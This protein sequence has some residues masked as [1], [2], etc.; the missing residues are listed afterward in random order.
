[1]TP[2]TA[3]VPASAQNSQAK[4]DLAS[5]P[6]STMATENPRLTAQ[7]TRPYA[8]GR[9]TGGTTSAISAAEAGRY[10]SMVKPKSSVAATIAGRPRE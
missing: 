7:N 8:R 6:P 9:S 1:M 5:A 4:P 3:Q 10:R 2:A